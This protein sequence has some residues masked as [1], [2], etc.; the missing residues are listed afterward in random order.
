MSPKY[1]NFSLAIDARIL[2]SEGGRIESAT[3]LAVH[4]V[5]RFMA[6]SRFHYIRNSLRPAISQGKA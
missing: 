6:R 2:S 4:R 5:N 1:T 3:S